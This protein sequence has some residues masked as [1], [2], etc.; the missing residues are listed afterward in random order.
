MIFTRLARKNGAAS[1]FALA[2]ALATGGMIGA[3]ALEAPAVAQKKKKESNWQ[4]FSAIRKLKNY[5]HGY[6]NFGEPIQL[7]QFLESHVP[8]WRDCRNAE[9]EKKPAWLTPAVNELANNVMTRINRAATGR[10]LC[11]DAEMRSN[12]LA[13]PR[14]AMRCSRSMLQRNGCGRCGGVC[15]G[16]PARSGYI[17][18]QRVNTTAPVENEVR[19]VFTNSYLRG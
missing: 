6:V 10:I 13:L 9:P 19:I 2:I 18:N 4:V 17:L 1:T 15:A 16:M 8:N 12:G 3:A 7:N 14:L 11:L 5:G